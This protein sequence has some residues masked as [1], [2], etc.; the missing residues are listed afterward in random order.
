MDCRPENLKAMCQRCHLS[1]D[2]DEHA[3]NAAKTRRR[4]KIEAG[5]LE[6]DFDLIKPGEI[7]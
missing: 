4:K 1:F 5:Q 2:R 7:K 3:L 6:F